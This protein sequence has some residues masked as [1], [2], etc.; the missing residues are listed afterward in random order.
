MLFV[1]CVRIHVLEGRVQTRL[2]EQYE[3]KVVAHVFFKMLA[4]T[5]RAYEYK[6]P[7]RIPWASSR[8]TRPTK[9]HIQH[10][11]MYICINVFTEREHNILRNSHYNMLSCFV[12]VCC[13]ERVIRAC[14]ITYNHMPVTVGWQWDFLNSRKACAAPAFLVC[15][16]VSTCV[17]VV[18]TSRNTTSMQHK[19]AVRFSLTVHGIQQIEFATDTVEM[20]EKI[21]FYLCSCIVRT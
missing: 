17:C 2:E 13:L 21:T 7:K 14:N 3:D 1:R 18:R 8:L 16:G 15:F 9:Q 5:R 4:Q 10:I 6:T 11:Y 12:C 20:C 19:H